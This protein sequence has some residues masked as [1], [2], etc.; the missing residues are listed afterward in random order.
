VA[1]RRGAANR[2]GC[3]VQLALL[4]HPGMTLAQM[5]VPIEPLVT[6]LAS[7]LEIPDC[8]IRQVRPPATDDDR[9]CTCAGLGTRIT[10][11]GC[12]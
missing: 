3:A 5:D 2:L 9:P 8:F 11:S 7:Q 1:S 6:W 12:G 10:A 4:R